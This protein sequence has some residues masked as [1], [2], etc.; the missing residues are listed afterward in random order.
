[1]T[2]DDVLVDTMHI[3]TALQDFITFL[4]NR[5]CQ[6]ILVGH[7]IIRFDNPRLRNAANNCGLLGELNE[8]VK[9]CIDTYEVFRG[10]YRN[11]ASYKQENLVARYLHET[12]EAH[13]AVADATILK[14]L[15]EAKLDSEQLGKYV[16]NFS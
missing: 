6:P 10:E 16:R 5:A 8:A 9:R 3:R 15:V 4:R 7:N 12:Y 11:L 14:K 2:K 13:G 1:M